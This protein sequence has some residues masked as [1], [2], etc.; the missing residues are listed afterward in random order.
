MS[1]HA[2]TLT[3]PATFEREDCC[4]CAVIF[5][6]PTDLQKRA[7][8]D[9]RSFYCPNGHP[10]SYR[11]TEAARLRKQL[12][13]STAALQSEKKRKEWA[14][15]ALRLKTEWA[16]KLTKEAKRLKKRAAAGVCP[17]CHRTVA[18]M[19]RHIK[20]KHPDYAVTI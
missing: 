8:A 14:E 11:E 10:Q 12:E 19:A 4:T 2:I 15:E 3:E 9:S 1:T 7:K 13:E 16:N 17:C 5:F 6:V 20:T 18:Q